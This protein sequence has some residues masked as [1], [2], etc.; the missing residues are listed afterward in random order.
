MT[1]STFSQLNT[2]SVF[3]FKIYVFCSVK[4]LSKVD[5]PADF[6]Y[7]HSIISGFRIIGNIFGF[8]DLINYVSISRGSRKKKKSPTKSD[9]SYQ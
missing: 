5:C 6:V 9:K 3:Y 1:T 2:T 4:G 8:V 7:K